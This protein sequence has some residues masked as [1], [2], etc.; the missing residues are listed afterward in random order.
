MEAMTET[1]P[2]PAAI[3]AKAFME[4]IS[5]DAYQSA[6][7][8]RAVMGGWVA[9]REAGVFDVKLNDAIAKAALAAVMDLFRSWAAEADEA[10][11][12]L[13][14]A[15]AESEAWLLGLADGK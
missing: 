13:A 7:E 15:D 12:E 2:T 4:R 9:A 8:T 10:D 11:R 5:G 14:G 3:A 1:G 6:I